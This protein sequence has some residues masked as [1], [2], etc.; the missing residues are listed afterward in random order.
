MTKDL[1]VDFRICFIVPSILDYYNQ[2]QQHGALLTIDY[3]LNAL[4]KS[5]RRNLNHYHSESFLS[6]IYLKFLSTVS[7]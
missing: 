5:L 3:E 7:K 2:T 6:N 4:E 1:L